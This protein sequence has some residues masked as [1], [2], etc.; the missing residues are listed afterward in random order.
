MV[1]FTLVIALLKGIFSG[2]SVLVGGLAYWLPTVLF[3]FGVSWYAP[4]RRAIRF[5]A[6]FMLGETLKLIL[7]GVCF[8]LLVKYAQVDLLYAL[9]GIIAAIIAFWIASAMTFLHQPGVKT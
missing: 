6:A 5:M 3:V 7:S 9:I 8:L 2:L 1:G 4:A